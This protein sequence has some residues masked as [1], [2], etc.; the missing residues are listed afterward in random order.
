M[1]VI[2]CFTSLVITL[3]FFDPCENPDARPHTRS[4]VSQEE[5]CTKRANTRGLCGQHGGGKRC[6]FV[7]FGGGGGAAAGAAGATAAG[8]TA[9]TSTEESVKTGS[10]T[11]PHL[12]LSPT[13]FCLRHGGGRRCDEVLNGENGQE[14]HRSGGGSRTCQRAA[15]GTSSKCYE[16]GGRLVYDMGV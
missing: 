16:H 13:G 6:A 2:I 10:E 3:I 15:C 5:G 9:A 7:V 1:F 4:P 14:V 8:N 12:A 11:C